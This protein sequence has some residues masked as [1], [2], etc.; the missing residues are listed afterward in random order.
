MSGHKHT[1]TGTSVQL[2][3]S[4]TLPSRGEVWASKGGDLPPWTGAGKAGGRLGKEEE[5]GSG[6]RGYWRSEFQQP[7]QSCAG[8]GSTAGHG[9]VVHW[10]HRVGS[11]DWDSSCYRSG[12]KSISWGFLRSDCHNRVFSFFLFFPLF[13]FLE[14]GYHSVGRGSCVSSISKQILKY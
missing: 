10:Q 6:S 4:A 14:E 7:W 11:Q 8:A 3:T 2:E 12:L 13:Y 1:L 9:Q 5:Q